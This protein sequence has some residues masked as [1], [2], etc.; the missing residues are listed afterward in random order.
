MTSDDFYGLLFLITIGTL[1]AV[2]A[3]DECIEMA[4]RRAMGL[5]E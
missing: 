5:H 3:A 4:Y 1:L 2:I